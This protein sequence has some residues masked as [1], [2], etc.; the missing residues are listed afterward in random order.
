M[1]I[2]EFRVYLLNT[3]LNDTTV[4]YDFELIITSQHLEGA[5]WRDVKPN[6]EVGLKH[7][8]PKHLWLARPPGRRGFVHAFRRQQSTQDRAR[9]IDHCRVDTP[10]GWTDGDF[11]SSL[12][13]FKPLDTSVRTTKGI[14]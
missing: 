5:D 9:R 1:Q 7:W 4:A 3:Y 14:L 6:P 12:A 13:S 10:N 11:Q 2:T 8:E